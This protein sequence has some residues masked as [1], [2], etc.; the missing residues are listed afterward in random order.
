[1]RRDQRGEQGATPQ[2]R[3]QDQ[4]TNAPKAQIMSSRALQ[5]NFDDS[6][7]LHQ[8]FIAQSR[9]TNDNDEFNVSG[10]EGG[11]GGAGGGGERGRGG[12]R[13]NDRR[14][15]GGGRGGGRGRGA[16]RKHKHHGGGEDTE[17]R[18]CSPAERAK[19][20]SDQKSELKAIHTTRED[21]Q[22]A[23]STAQ[24]L[25]KMAAHEKRASQAETEQEA[26]DKNDQDAGNA[27]W[28]HK[29]LKKPNRS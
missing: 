28:S 11:G 14:G 26:G 20:N 21:K 25:T 16:D 5:D 8:D 1:M 3:N 12:G 2:R 22:D 4:Q 23:R 15:R 17:D 9:P 18:H 24:L 10:F 7:G 29:A 6:V 13:H 27:N 19:L